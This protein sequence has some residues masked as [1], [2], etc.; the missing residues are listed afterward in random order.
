MTFASLRFTPFSRAQQNGQEG[1]KGSSR[2]SQE[3]DEGN[4]GQEGISQIVGTRE[5][6]LSIFDHLYERSLLV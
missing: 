5:R 6:T 1:S 4:E 3:G 2:S